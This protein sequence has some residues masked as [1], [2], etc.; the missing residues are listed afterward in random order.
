M[1]QDG[2]PLA[3][4]PHELLDCSAACRDRC[5]PFRVDRRLPL[6][7]LHRRDLDDGERRGPR[8][9]LDCRPPLAARRHP[10]ADAWCRGRVPRTAVPLESESPPLR[11]PRADGI[12]PGPRTGRSSVTSSERFYDTIA[13]DFDALM[14][15]YDL[16]RRLDVVFG[17]LLSGRPLSARTVLDVG[18]GTGAFTLAAVE[19]GGI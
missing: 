16:E 18:C 6:S 4:R 8:M 9:G 11:D 7:R 19:R 1:A 2:A 12:G 17:E 15:P 10:T 14:N 13:D 3:R 5:R